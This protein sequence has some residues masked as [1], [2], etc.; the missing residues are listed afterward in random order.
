MTLWKTI[1]GHCIHRSPSGA[2]VY[3]NLFYRWLTFNSDALQSL[4][5]RKHPEKPMFGYISPLTLAA[6]TVPGETCLLGLGG[7]AVAHTLAPH[8]KTAGITAVDNNLDIIHIASSY[9]MTERL[10]NMAV[11]QDDANHFV[12]KCTHRYQHLMVDLYNADAFPT[13]CNTLDFFSNCRRLLR[14]NGIFA[15]NIANLNEQWLL[16]QRVRDCFFKKTVSFPIKGSSNMVILACNSPS[17]EPLLALLK[18]SRRIKKL[19]WD[20][21]WGCI[22]TMV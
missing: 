21:R 5:R 19:S 15:L 1:G 11:I 6:R 3:Q 20:A 16:A 18:N 8:L 12:K 22:A 9:F 14:P 7:A 13:Q 10:K 4:I 2:C 17:V